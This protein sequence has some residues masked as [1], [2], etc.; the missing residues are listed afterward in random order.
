MARATPFGAPWDALT[1]DE[2]R[3]F[4]AV[5]GRN[6]SLTW[7]AK[8]GPPDPKE[9][10]RQVCGFANT[11]LGG[12]LVLGAEQHKQTASW[13]LTGS[14]FPDT[15]PDRWVSGVVASRLDR[16]PQ[17]DVRSYEMG[18]G[19]S[20][21]V[22]WVPPSPVPPCVTSLGEVY[23]RI[24]GQT[25]P[26]R[27]HEELARLFAKGDG[28]RVE[29]TRRS[30]DAAQHLFG[31]F[32]SFISVG[33]A[34][35]AFERDPNAA[36]FRD[37]VKDVVM[38]VM[39]RE[40]SMWPPE[41]PVRITH[42]VTLI[43]QTY[44]QYASP[45]DEGYAVA[46]FVGGAVGVAKFHPEF[47]SATELLGESGEDPLRSLWNA[48]LRVLR[49]TGAYGPVQVHMIIADATKGAA[50]VTRWQE[51][52]S[53]DVDSAALASVARE[54]LRVRSRWAPEP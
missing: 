6:E 34:P 21:A 32:R 4:F 9:V 38:A 16:R 46:V 48:C 30:R 53:T 15:D 44:A 29:A 40:L 35:T 28:A 45:G 37:D 43:E 47:V 49:S 19:Q 12:Y 52:L 14:R 54:C 50:S 25:I 18:G 17:I 27:S 33:M 11:V 23:E 39:R 36:P 22:V 42:P 26:I 1:V 41:T 10:A 31:T 24:P 51:D 2:L 5:Q 8:G 3:T 20:V 13:S 7:E